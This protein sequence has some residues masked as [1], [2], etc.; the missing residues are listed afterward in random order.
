MGHLFTYLKTCERGRVKDFEQRSRVYN[1]VRYNTFIPGGPR[2]NGAAVNS[3][4]NASEVTNLRLVLIQ[5][6]LAKTSTYLPWCNEKYVVK[7]GNIVYQNLTA[8]LCL[9]RM[10]SME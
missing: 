9:Q 3:Y 8:C 2:Y 1:A 6:T 4:N 7:A 5:Q 10:S